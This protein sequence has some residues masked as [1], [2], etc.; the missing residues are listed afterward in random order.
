MMTSFKIVP[1]T[2]PDWE[3]EVIKQ[4]EAIKAALLSNYPLAFGNVSG[5]VLEFAAV[6]PI[7][8]FINNGEKP[9]NRS[10]CPRIPPGMEDDCRNMINDLESQGVIKRFDRATDWCAP[11]RFILKHSGNSRLVINF[12]G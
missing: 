7:E 9:I 10:T 4:G 2:S 3:T 5:D 1:T 8:V 11:A 12:Q 6:K